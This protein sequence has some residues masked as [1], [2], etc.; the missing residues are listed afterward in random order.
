MRH[1]TE[2][3]TFLDAIRRIGRAHEASY[4]VANV[5][6]A[7]IEMKRA[8]TDTPVRQP[9][10]QLDAGSSRKLHDKFCSL[11]NVIYMKKSELFQ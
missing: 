4:S 1:F 11:T 2:C 3:S 10:A 8:A 6:G 7:L 5:H 9:G